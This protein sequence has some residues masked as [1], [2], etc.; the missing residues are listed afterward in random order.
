MPCGCSN[1]IPFRANTSHLARS[2]S[3]PWSSAPWYGGNSSPLSPWPSDG[4]RPSTVRPSP[5]SSGQALWLGAFEVARFWA[6]LCAAHV[7][8]TFWYVLAA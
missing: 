7:V 8:N 5:H 1:E 2:A 6:K 4:N 3:F